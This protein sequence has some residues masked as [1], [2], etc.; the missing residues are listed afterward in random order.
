MLHE[1]SN[2]LIEQNNVYG[3]RNNSHKKNCIKSTKSHFVSPISYFPCQLERTIYTNQ[4][5]A[6]SDGI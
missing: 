6:Q 2:S 3:Q 4:K 5:A 1:G